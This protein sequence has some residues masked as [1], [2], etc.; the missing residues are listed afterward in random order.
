MPVAGGEARQITVNGGFEGYE[1]PD[2]KLFYFTKGRGVKGIYSVPANGGEEKP[3]SE[4]PVSE[5]PVPEL[6]SVC[7]CVYCS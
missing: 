4:L 6:R 3:V 1:S 7:N 5:L 2:G